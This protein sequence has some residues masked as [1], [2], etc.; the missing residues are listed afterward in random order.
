MFAPFPVQSGDNG[1]SFRVSRGGRGPYSIDEVDFIA[2]FIAK[3]DAW[4]LIP[5]ESVSKKTGI[6]LYLGKR[7]IKPGCGLFEQY[8]ES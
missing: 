1:F 5:V 6:N 7:R 8:R 2:A 4:Y 3:H